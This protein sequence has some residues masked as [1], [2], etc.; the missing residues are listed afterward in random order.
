MMAR[1]NANSLSPKEQAMTTIPV[2]Q[3]PFCFLVFCLFSNSPTLLPPLAA[4]IYSVLELIP[5]YPIN[6]SICSLSYLN[7]RI[8][9]R[10][11]QITSE[12]LM[13]ALT[14]Y[15]SKTPNFVPY[16]RYIKQDI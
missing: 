16:C 11:P 4:V 12:R 5:F 7:Q 6:C 9:M 13:R 14:F 2:L 10:A 15:Q 8:F 3:I 1:L